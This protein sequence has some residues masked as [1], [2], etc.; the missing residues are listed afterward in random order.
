M[1]MGQKENPSILRPRERQGMN[2][3]AHHG[4]RVL[5]VSLLLNA[6]SLLLNVP[7][8]QKFT[9]HLLC[10]WKMALDRTDPIVAPGKTDRE[11]INKTMRLWQVVL[12]GLDRY[13]KL[14][15][16][17]ETASLRSDI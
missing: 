15:F 17:G 8:Q 5:H 3:E 1:L 2:L 10:A 13:W 4:P 6:P 7:S 9:G 16:G 11:R 12:R 14:R